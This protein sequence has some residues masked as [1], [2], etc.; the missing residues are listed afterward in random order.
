MRLLLILGLMLLIPGCVDKDIPPAPTKNITS[1]EECVKA[2]YPILE[3]YP[4]QCRT[5]DGRIFISGTDFMEMNQN[6]T[7][8][9]DEDCKLIDKSLGFGC[10]W[11]GACA[12]INYSEDKWIALNKEWFDGIQNQYCPDEFDCGPA[13]LCAIRAIDTN[14][15]ASCINNSCKKIPIINQEN[16]TANLT[17]PNLTTNITIP[18]NISTE[19]KSINNKTANLSGLII[20]NGSYILVLED[21]STV[22]NCALLSVVYSSNQT[23]ITKLKGCPGKDVNWISPEGRVFRIKVVKTAAGYTKNESWADIR[24]YG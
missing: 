13:P 22:D 7:C 8:T 3:S 1:F 17:I 24:V 23:E 5:P 21:I 18:E 12:Q 10:C 11:S 20:A 14:Y 19:N 16:I 2:G 15:T 9:V 6:T 4:R